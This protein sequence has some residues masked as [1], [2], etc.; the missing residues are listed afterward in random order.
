[1]DSVAA[2][3]PLPGLHLEHSRQTWPGDYSRLAQV[4]ATSYLLLPT[5][6]SRSASE[7]SV[8]TLP[9]SQRECH[10]TVYSPED[11]GSTVSAYSE[12]F[13]RLSIS[14]CIIAAILV[15][16]RFYQMSKRKGT[17][18]CE[19]IMSGVAMVRQLQPDLDACILQLTRAQ[20]LLIVM[21]TVGCQ[22]S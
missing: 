13:I 8:S 7:D 19:D 9:K 18:T 14:L 5:D 16:N 17:L 10:G 3:V 22:G 11:T 20:V 15:V 4:T 1:M 6:P 12:L 21:T 2:R